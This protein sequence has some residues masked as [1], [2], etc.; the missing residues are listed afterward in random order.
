MVL[1]DRIE[2]S[3]S[4]LPRECSTTELQQRSIEGPPSGPRPAWGAGR[5]LQRTISL[6]IISGPGKPLRVTDTKQTREERLAAKLRENLRLRKAQARAISG[7]AMK[8]E[9]GN[10]ELPK[11]EGD[12]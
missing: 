8:T 3:A 12:R 7:S 10:A 1:L 2:L 6:S 9:I 4:P 5:A 11:P